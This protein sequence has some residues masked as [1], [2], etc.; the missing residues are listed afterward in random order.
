VERFLVGEAIGAKLRGA[1][2]RAVDD[3]VR[4]APNG[5]G[6]VGVFRQVQ[7]E[8]ADIL[9]RVDSLSL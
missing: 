2:K 5:G 8:M 6:E 1:D 3:E 4:I 7:P 9:R